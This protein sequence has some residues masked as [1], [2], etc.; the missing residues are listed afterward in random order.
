MAEAIRG[1]LWRSLA[2]VVN[3]HKKS[4]AGRPKADDRRVLGGIVYV[5]RTGIP[6]AHMP[7]ELGLASGMTC[8]RRL[9]HWQQHGQWPDIERLLKQHLPFAQQIDWQRA[10]RGRRRARSMPA[11]LA[12]PPPKPRPGPADLH[13]DRLSTLA[14]GLL[15]NFEVAP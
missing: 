8:L 3:E 2:K 1:E 10:D 13:I 5:L 11:A 6:W 7:R 15:E 9:R 4:T 12:I 14:Q